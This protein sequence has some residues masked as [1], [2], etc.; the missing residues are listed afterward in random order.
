MRRPHSAVVVVTALFWTIVCLATQVSSS[1][2]FQIRLKSLVNERGLNDDGDCCQGVRTGGICTSAC[3]TFFRICLKQYQTHITLD[4]P[5]TFGAVTTPV[6]GNNSFTLPDN[7]DTFENPIDLPFDFSWPGTFSLIIEALHDRTSNGPSSGSPRDLVLRLMTQRSVAVQSEW[8]DDSI[9]TATSKL[10]YRYRVICEPDYFGHGCSEMC[11]ARDDKFGHYTCS[12][13]GTRVCLE[14]WTGP[15][16]DKAACLDGCD[17][18]HGSCEKPNECKCRM[19]WQGKFCD[20]CIPYPG[21]QHGTCKLQPWQCNCEEGWGGLFCNQDLNYCTHHKPC[22]NDAT[23]TNTGQ[24]SYTCKCAA[25]F[26]GTNCEIEVDDCQQ[27]PCFNGGTCTDMGSTYQCRCPVGFR[28]QQCESSA[29]SCDESPCLNDGTCSMTGDMYH[30]RCPSGFTGDNCGVEVDEC[31]SNP[32]LNGGRCIDEFDGFRCIC[33]P[34]YSGA[35]CHD[36]PNDCSLQPCL[37]GA[38]CHDGVNEF[39]CRCVPGFVGPLCQT[40]VDDCATRPCA[41][42][43]TCHDLINDFACDCAPGFSGKDCRVDT[44]ECAGAPCLNGAT[45]ADRVNGYECACATGYYGK[46]CDRS[47]AHPV[48]TT[49]G[50]QMSQTTP[51]TTMKATTTTTVGEHQ[52]TDGAAGVA[53]SNQ[54]HAGAAMADVTMEQLLLIICLGIGIPIIIIIGIIIF[55]LLNQRRNRRRNR[56][57]AAQARPENFDNEHNEIRTAN[58]KAK[59]IDADPTTSVRGHLTINNECDKHHHSVNEDTSAKPKNYNKDINKTKNNSSNNSRRGRSCLETRPVD[60]GG[61]DNM[62]DN[63]ALAAPRSGVS[64]TLDAS[65]IA[66]CLDQPDL[67][68]SLRANVGETGEHAPRPLTFSKSVNAPR[69]DNTS[70]FYLDRHPLYPP[71]AE[72]MLATEV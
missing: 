49:G 62:S 56:Q 70:I 38:T 2:K 6:V 25:G 58:N 5:C 45:C 63:A 64:R 26:T 53:G 41:N 9:E 43:A 60:G 13:N 52:T 67:A 27:Q 54:A 24:G 61:G 48:K 46:N 21:C 8:T 4:S 57:A 37:N 42:G 17:E 29:T 34:G 10:E 3:S 16:C 66:A 51:M 35:T 19:G 36:N 18:L 72:G 11:R 50:V 28:G 30:C 39:V 47:V 71:Y 59:A 68:A 20:R 65:A 69:D 14:G 44:D 33:R 22:K 7:L 40:N 12:A 32:C 31:A 15:Y 55:L 23:C 1:G